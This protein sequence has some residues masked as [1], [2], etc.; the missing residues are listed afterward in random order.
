MLTDLGPLD[1]FPRL[2]RLTIQDQPRLEAL[3]VTGVPLK[4]LLVD[5]CKELRQITGLDRSITKDVRTKWN[6]KLVQ[7]A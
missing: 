3:D 1:R 2:E 7:P 4:F 5:Q 6:A